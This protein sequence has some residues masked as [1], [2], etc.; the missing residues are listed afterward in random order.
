M[1][2]ANLFISISS[3]LLEPDGSS[4]VYFTQELVSNLN[5]LEVGITNSAPFE[6]LS[7]QRCMTLFCL[8]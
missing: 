7:G 1:H 3:H 2:L 5:Y 4:D 8:V 6:M